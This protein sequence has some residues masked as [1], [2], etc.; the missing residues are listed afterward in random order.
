M[1][2]DGEISKQEIGKQQADHYQ[3]RFARQY[4]F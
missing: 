3:E 1:G 2:V 4:F